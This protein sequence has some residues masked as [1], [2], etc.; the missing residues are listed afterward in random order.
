M[1]T[2]IVG[3]RLKRRDRKRKREKKKSEKDVAMR[4]ANHTFC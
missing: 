3:L 1:Q 2:K 4:F